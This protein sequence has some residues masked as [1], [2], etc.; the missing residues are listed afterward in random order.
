MARD[1]MAGRLAAG[2]ADAT[3]RTDEEVERAVAVAVVAAVAAA[4][5]VGALRVLDRLDE[6]GFAV[7]GHAGHRA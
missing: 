2:V 1:G 3:G 5:L 6:L 4:A 7:L